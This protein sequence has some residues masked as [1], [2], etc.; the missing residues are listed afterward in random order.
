M[1]LKDKRLY[2]TVNDRSVL[3]R[4]KANQSVVKKSSLTS[5]IVLTISF[6]V[7]QENP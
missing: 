1:Y 3:I 6:I 4:D 7:V 5:N 2:L